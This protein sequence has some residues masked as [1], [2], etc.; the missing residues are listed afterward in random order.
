V[1]M[2]WREERNLR[3]RNPTWRFA[4]E[5][6]GQFFQKLKQQTVIFRCPPLQSL[7]LHSIATLQS[8]FRIIPETLSPIVRLQ[9]ASRRRV[10]NSSRG[11]TFG[12]RWT[13]PTSPQPGPWHDEYHPAAAK[14]ALILAR[15][16][17]RAARLKAA[18]ARTLADPFL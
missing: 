18:I 8:Y 5:L 17:K 16:A 6:L 15:G 9:S 10:P 13:N 4:P 7:R 3:Y 1:Q 11:K 2:C 12:Q 14:E